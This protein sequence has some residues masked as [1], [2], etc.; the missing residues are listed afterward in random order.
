MGSG[1]ISV[2]HQ[3]YSYKYKD[4]PQ[5]TFN[6]YKAN[7]I[8]ANGVFHVVTGLRWQPPSGTPGDPKVSQ[9]PP[10][11]SP[12]MLGGLRPLQRA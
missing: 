1:Q 2:S 10:F 7:N 12:V 6:I 4:Q 11:P 3:K 9:H 8:A 5:Q